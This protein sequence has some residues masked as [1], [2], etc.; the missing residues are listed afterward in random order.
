MSRATTDDAGAKFHRPFVEPVIDV[1]K[2]ARL[3]PLVVLR[4]VDAYFSIECVGVRTTD[5][6]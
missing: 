4:R 5:N 3:L 2:Y 1:E 6:E